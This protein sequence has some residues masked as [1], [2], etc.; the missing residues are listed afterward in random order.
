MMIYTLGVSPIQLESSAGSS[1][2]RP[3]LV[4]PNISGTT[5][6]RGSTYL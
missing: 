1:M 6:T 2:L 5:T 4:D 3:L